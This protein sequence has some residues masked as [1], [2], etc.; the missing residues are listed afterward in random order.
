MPYVRD[1][2]PLVRPTKGDGDLRSGTIARVGDGIF[3]VDGEHPAGGEL[4]KD[5]G[6]HFVMILEGVIVVPRWSTTS[7]SV[8]VVLFL[9][10]NS[11]AKLR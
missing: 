1:V 4:S 5:S 11:L 6:D 2:R 9:P 3:C 7:G 10:W 8:V